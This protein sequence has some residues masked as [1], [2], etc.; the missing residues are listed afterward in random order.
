[1]KSHV[2]Q[3]DERCD[4]EERKREQYKE[5]RKNFNCFSAIKNFKLTKN[6]PKYLTIAD[7]TCGGERRVP[8]LKRPDQN[9]LY[10]RRRGSDPVFKLTMDDE[11]MRRRNSDPVCVRQRNNDPV[12]SHTDPVT[13]LRLSDTEDDLNDASTAVS[14]PTSNEDIEPFAL[15]PGMVTD[16]SVALVC[17][18]AQKLS[19]MDGCIT[20]L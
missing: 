7:K 6:R 8:V 20:S 3:P 14:D 10:M 5:N 1:M 9:S 13:V 12:L 2:G 17:A 16:T 19:T 4:K 15:L 11:C 18:H